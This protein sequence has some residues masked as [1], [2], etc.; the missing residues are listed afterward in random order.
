[1]SSLDED[2]V[3]QHQ[4]AQVRESRITLH[5]LISALGKHLIGGLLKLRISGLKELTLHFE[6]KLLACQVF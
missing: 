5:I 2:Q 6:L 4:L 3:K 1:M